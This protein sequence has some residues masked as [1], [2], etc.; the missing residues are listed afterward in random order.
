M[1]RILE[2]AIPKTL[3]DVV[4][5]YVAVNGIKEGDFFEQNYVKKIYPAQIGNKLWSSIQVTTAAGVCG[6]FEIVTQN[7]NAYHGFVTQEAI[8][9]DS[10]IN[11][12]FGKYFA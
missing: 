6:V 10:V 7:S 11:N 12:R 5:I 9:L 4:L 2:N 1:K 8:E 3:Q